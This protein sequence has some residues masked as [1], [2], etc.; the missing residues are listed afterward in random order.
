[1]VKGWKLIPAW[2]E[3]KE[4]KAAEKIQRQISRMELEAKIQLW[5]EEAKEFERR[6]EQQRLSIKSE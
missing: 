6:F 2:V 4:R 5:E 3:L 1:M